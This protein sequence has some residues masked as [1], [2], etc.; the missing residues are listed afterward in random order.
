MT[1]SGRD[2][3]RR[4]R[5]PAA[6]RHPGLP[7]PLVEI[8]GRPI[9]WHVIQIYAAQGLRDF[10]L[11][12]GYKGELI[13]EFAGRD[14][15]PEGVRVECVD[16]GL[17]TP[18]GGRIHRVGDRVRRRDVPRDVRRRRGRR[19]PAPAAAPSTRRTARWRR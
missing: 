6:G 18:T 19:R 13:E 3:L 11:R 15:W 8:G 7:K 5:D 14:A 17:D 9:L 4:P 10:V 12:T 2:P 1:P 16:T